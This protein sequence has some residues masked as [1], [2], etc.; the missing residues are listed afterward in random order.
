VMKGD[1][2]D[3]D[4]RIHVHKGLVRVSLW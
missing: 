3:G 2:G 4:D 1:D